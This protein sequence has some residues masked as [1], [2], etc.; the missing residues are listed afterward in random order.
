MSGHLLDGRHEPDRRS[1]YCDQPG[2]VK[3]AVD[4]A[5]VIPRCPVHRVAMKPEDE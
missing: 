4:Q 1:Y 5:G 3:T 2:C